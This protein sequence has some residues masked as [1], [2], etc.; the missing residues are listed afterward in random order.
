MTCL[1]I[2]RVFDAMLMLF[3]LVGMLTG[4]TVAKP[5]PQSYLC[6]YVAFWCKV[7]HAHCMYNFVQLEEM[8]H[9]LNATMYRGLEAAIHGCRRDGKPEFEN[10]AGLSIEG[11]PHIRDTFT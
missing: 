4:P 2:R 8:A 7:R 3:D 6:C 11:V 1:Y 9:E 5:L 10:G